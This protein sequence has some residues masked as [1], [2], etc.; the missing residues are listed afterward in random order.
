MTV[1]APFQG[2][3]GKNNV[4]SPNG[5]SASAG[6]NANSKSV[7]LV[8][9]GTHICHVRIGLSPQTASTLDLPVLP[10][11][12]IVVQKAM[13]DDTVAY[14]SADGTTLHIQSGEGG[15]C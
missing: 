3:L 13:G 7:R 8:N 4:V 12:A 14:I 11:S 15:F 2:I 9:S 1:H 5:T 10:N 6:I